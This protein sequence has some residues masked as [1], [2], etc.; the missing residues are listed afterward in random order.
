MPTPAINLARDMFNGANRRSTVAL[1]TSAMCLAGWYAIGNYKFWLDHVPQP[2]VIHDDLELSAAVWSLISTVLLLGI[3][4]MIVVKLIF[5]DRLADYGLR[6]GDWKFSL[7]CSLLA[8][9][10]MV[11]IG[12]AS[13]QM[14]AFQALYPLCPLAK[15]SGT[16]LAWDLVGQLCWYAAWEFHF[17]G[18]LQSALEKANGIPIAICVQ[19]LASTLAHFG[20]PGS[21]VFAAILGGLLWGA[22]TWRTRSLLGSFFQHWLLGASL[23]FFLC[24]T[25]NS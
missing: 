3:V 1:L 7:R 24:W 8:A 12:Y 5:G 13:A 15:Q 19:T 9:P 11:A 25:A 21:E 10:L 18:F 16:A 4:P 23:D 6:W 20:R 17:R 2:M 14:P 22:L